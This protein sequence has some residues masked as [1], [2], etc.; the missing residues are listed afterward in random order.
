MTPD[1]AA[2]LGA[3]RE[4]ALRTEDVHERQR[5]RNLYYA[6]EEEMRAVNAGQAARQAREAG[7]VNQAT[8]PATS[9]LGLL[10]NQAAGMNAANAQEGGR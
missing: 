6:M 1:Q 2:Q 7:T 9:Q 3:L 10:T 5:Y 8:L 4:L